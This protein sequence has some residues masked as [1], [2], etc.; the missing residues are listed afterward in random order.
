MRITLITGMT[1]AKKRK[2][3]PGDWARKRMKDAKASG[4]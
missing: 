1:G 3:N 4:M 2:R